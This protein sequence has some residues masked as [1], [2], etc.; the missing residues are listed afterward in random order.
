ME[1]NV[2]AAALAEYDHSAS[3]SEGKQCVLFVLSD[4]GLGVGIIMDGKLY[5]GPRMS[6]G[7]F[8]QMVIADQGGAETHDRPGCFEKMVCNPAIWERYAKLTTGRATVQSGDSAARVKRICHR[9]LD[10]E[11]EAVETLQSTARFLGIGLSNLIWGLDPDVIVLNATINVAWSMV[12]PVITAQFA[13]S[14]HWPSFQR[15]ILRPS[16]LG[17]QAALIGATSLPFARIFQTA[18]RHRLTTEPTPAG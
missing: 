13:E 12:L 18:D 2:R 6:A 15:V 9:A 16:E 8:G 3:E 14:E 1:N 5:H 7:E 10:G 17:D 4:E 11:P